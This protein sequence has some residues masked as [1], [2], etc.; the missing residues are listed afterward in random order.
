MVKG[1]RSWIESKELE[2]RVTEFYKNKAN[3]GLKMTWHFF[4]PEGIPRANM[5]SYIKKVKESESVEFKKPSGRPVKLGTTKVKNRIRKIFKT[6]PSTPTTVA[7]R[8]INISQSY[9][10]KIKIHKLGIKTRTKK[11][12][13]NY[14]NTQKSRIVECRKKFLKKMCGK[15][16]IMDDE[17]YVPVD[18]SNVP[19]RHLYHSSNPSEVVYEEKIRKNDKFPTKFYIWQCMSGDGHVSDPVTLDCN[20]N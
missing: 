5:Y 4:K 16:V 19:G 7:A 11:P 2:K 18:P 12:A 13:P 6:Q 8:K 15:V 10:V 20:I 14:K 9:L 3:S 17:T 1:R